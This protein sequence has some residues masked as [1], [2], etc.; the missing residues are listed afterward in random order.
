MRFA[1]PPETRSS[2][3]IRLADPVEQQAWGEF[4]DLYFPVFIRAAQQYGMQFADAEDVAQQVL[5]AVSDALVK[6]PHDR[7]QAKFRTWLS[8][9]IRNAAID[10]LSERRVDRGS[11]DTSAL[12]ALHQLEARQTSGEMI[13]HELQREVFHIAAQRI[14]HEFEPDTWQLFWRTTIVGESIKTVAAAY[15]KREGSVYAARSRIIRRLRDEV[16]KMESE[17]E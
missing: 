5:V 8:V 14:E 4:I 10:C 9:V 1:L 13:A 2:L 15:Q 3:L 7:K 11:G 16:A 12:R 17:W 6:R